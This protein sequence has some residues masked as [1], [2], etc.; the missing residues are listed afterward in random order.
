VSKALSVGACSAWFIARR[1]VGA[2]RDR[3]VT[4][5]AR[6]DS[7]IG[8]MARAPDVCPG[9]ESWMAA[10]ELVARLWTPPAAAVR[11]RTGVAAAAL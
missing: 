9:R 2:I 7:T 5:N 10:L 8:A 3:S 4:R 1:S 6:L 11:I